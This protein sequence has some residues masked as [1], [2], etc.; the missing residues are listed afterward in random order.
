[1][2]VKFMTGGN[3]LWSPVETAVEI[4]D[5]QIGYCDEDKDFGEL[6]VYFNT[7]T[8]DVAHDGLI[9]TDKDFL[10]ELRMFLTQ[11]GLAGDDVDYSEQG[12]QEYNYV[13]LDVGK[14][15]ID[16]WEAKFGEIVIVD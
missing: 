4:T 8:W 1:M 11:H 16:S 2:T 3:G 10:F 9:Y 14:A 15:F 6:C 13:S 7:A 5:M 12:M